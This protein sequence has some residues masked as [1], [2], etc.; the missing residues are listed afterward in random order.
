[1][2]TIGL[3]F[4]SVDGNF[5]PNFVAARNAGIRFS[6]PRA[7][8]GRSVIGGTTPFRDPV[9]ARD[10]DAILSAGLKRSAYLFL[11]YEKTGVYTPPPEEQADAFFDYVKL[12]GLQDLVPFFDVEEASSVMTA[13]LMYQWTLRCAQ[14]LRD[15]YGA[16]PGMYS[17]ARVWHENLKD[18][19]PGA[20][21]NC[22]LWLAKPWPWAIRT[23]IHLDGA[24]SYSPTPI[25]EWGNQWF[26]YQYGGDCTDC[27]GFNK[28]VDS[29]RLR[30][31]GEG[32]K[33]Q[34]VVWSQQRL[35]ITA[36]GIFGPK[37]KLAVQHL[38]SRFGLA[39]DGIIGLDTFCPLGWQ[40][41][42]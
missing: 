14:R 16:W 40:N 25:P 26:V 37:T 23:P 33:G 5:K 9:W 8:Y 30:V 1:M 15:L 34:H 4:A 2:T 32:A 39:A 6:I 17:S 28:T 7:I 21:I 41:P 18:H 42:A 29:N 38:Q 22:P 3:D 20:L 31:F 24:P 13:E 35:G 19:A 27:P 10:K 12:G 11:C 36:D